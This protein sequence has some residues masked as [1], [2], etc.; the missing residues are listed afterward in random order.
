MKAKSKTPE[1]R[2]FDT[3]GLTI[4]ELPVAELKAYKRNARTHSPKQVRQ[5]AGSIREFGF[6]NPILIDREST[7]LAGHGRSRPQSS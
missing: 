6:T 2:P 1:L 5:I 4:L 7:I 3:S